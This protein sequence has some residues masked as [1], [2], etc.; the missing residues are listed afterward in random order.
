MGIPNQPGPANA[1][2]TLQIPQAQGNPVVVLAKPP[3]KKILIPL[4][5][6]SNETCTKPQEREAIAVELLKLLVAAVPLLHVK[7][8]AF[9]AAEFATLKH[10]KQ[11]FDDFI[12]SLRSQPDQVIK[13]NQEWDLPETENV[14]QQR[15]FQHIY[16]EFINEQLDFFVRILPDADPEFLEVQIRGL[17]CTYHS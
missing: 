4:T 15:L 14:E 10:T 6:E 1:I 12:Q 11:Y 7:F 16:E 5:K 9:K 2:P 3:E 17:N 8:A 13:A